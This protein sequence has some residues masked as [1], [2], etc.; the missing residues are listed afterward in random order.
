ML[1]VSLGA[2]AF[3]MRL[4]LTSNGQ[5]T[6]SGQLYR[7]GF[8]KFRSFRPLAL[9]WKIACTPTIMTKTGTIETLNV[10]SLDPKLSGLT[11][12]IMNALQRPDSHG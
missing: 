3:R 11:G 10:A 9:T 1:S 8:E 7:L 2:P 6:E 5:M 12:L 4:G